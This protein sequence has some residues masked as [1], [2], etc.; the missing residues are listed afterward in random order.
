VSLTSRRTIYA[1][2]QVP[3]ARQ[4]R[5]PSP[6]APHHTPL[7]QIGQWKHLA[8]PP[9]HTLMPLARKFCPLARILASHARTS[10]HGTH[11]PMLQ[12]LGS[13]SAVRLLKQDPCRPRGFS[14]AGPNLAGRCLPVHSKMRDMQKPRLSASGIG[15]LGYRRG[16]LSEGVEART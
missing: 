4:L 5:S 2:M 3:N 8:C 10:M 11:A 7:G 13:R 12:S 14:E 16:T 15:P 6:L 9:V 1:N